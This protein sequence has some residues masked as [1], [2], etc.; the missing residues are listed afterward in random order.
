MI[1]R[2]DDRL[3]QANGPCFQKAWH[4]NKLFCDTTTAVRHEWQEWHAIARALYIR[5]VYDELETCLFS[6][7]AYVCFVAGFKVFPR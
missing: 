1:R 6:P 3:L 5:S 4:G 7:F 2:L